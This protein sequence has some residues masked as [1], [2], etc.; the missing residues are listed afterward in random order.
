MKKENQRTAFCACG[1]PTTKRDGA[2]H[3]CERCEKIEKQW[4]HH[5]SQHDNN[6]RKVEELYGN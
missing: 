4:E 3:V 1:N 6:L 2:G 5:S